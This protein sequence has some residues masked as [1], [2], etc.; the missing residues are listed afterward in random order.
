M[1][2]DSRSR[3]MSVSAVCAVSA[4]AL[5]A[6][7]SGGDSASSGSDKDKMNVVT[8]FYPLGFAAEQIGGDKVKVTSLT[9]PGAEPHD[10]ELSP[11]Q[12]A[13][14]SEADLTIY[15]KGFQPAVDSAVKTSAKSDK[16]LDVAP[17]ADLTLKLSE[18]TS[19]GEEEGHHEHEHEGESGHE[20]HNH[21]GDSDP[22]FWTDPVRYKAVATEIANRM[23]KA[24]PQNKA[25]YEANAKKFTDKLDKLNA[26]FKSGL[27]K[28]TN[29]NL[30]TGH[31]AFGYLA[32]RYGFKQ[33]G[34]AGVSPES[35][36][37]PARL[38]QVAAYAKK[39]N[40]KTIYSETLV[41]AKTSETVARE[42]GA[43]VQ[44][45]DPLEGITSASKGKDY[46]EVMQSN[47]TTLKS[48][49]S[50]K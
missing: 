49:Q 28:C 21:A 41:S 26:D 11:K 39:N 10:L 50:C 14:L 4:L 46:F 35:E 44:V 42:T 30:V 38:K 23:A 22:H 9:K 17:A 8:S 25:T 27:S 20:G 40:V 1:L 19:V 31:A 32:S 5:S 45:L 47:L 34:V 6:C 33:V 36:P 43:K 3:F 48:G 24:D 7:G 16:A 15:E 12:I 37:S 18:S 13:S 2:R 29:K